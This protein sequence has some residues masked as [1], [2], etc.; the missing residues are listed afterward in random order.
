MT[1]SKRENRY[2]S[3]V[4][5]RAAPVENA[6]VSEVSPPERVIQRGKKCMVWISSKT[7]LA[8]VFMSTL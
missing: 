1:K 8:A 7:S 6:T 2:T 4:R 5:T 3:E